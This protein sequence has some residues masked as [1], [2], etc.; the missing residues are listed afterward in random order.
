MGHPLA[1]GDAPC[2]LF[3]PLMTEWEARALALRERG[4]RGQRGKGVT[5]P[6]PDPA[7]CCSWARWAGSGAAGPNCGWKIPSLPFS[8]EQSA[9][10]ISCKGSK[11]SFSSSHQLLKGTGERQ[12]RFPRHYSRTESPPFREQQ[13]WRWRRS[14]RR[15]HVR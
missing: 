13:T 4:R 3:V 15:T 5:V 10:G 11:D 9:K 8:Q 7:S 1:R 6:C 2:L 12:G 14:H